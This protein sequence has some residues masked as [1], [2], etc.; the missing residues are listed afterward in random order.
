MREEERRGEECGGEERGGA[1]GE[2]THSTLNFKLWLITP[3]E[4]E[5]GGRR[6]GK[7][8]RGREREDKGQEEETG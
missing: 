7:R 3:R 6:R 2:L 1:A 8:K 4:G 5:M